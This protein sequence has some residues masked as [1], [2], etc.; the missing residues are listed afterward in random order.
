M[1]ETLDCRPPEVCVRHFRPWDIF[2]A[3]AYFLQG[4][5]ARQILV[6][7]VHGCTE[8]VANSHWLDFMNHAYQPAL[9]RAQKSASIV[10]MEILMLLGTVPRDGDALYLSSNYEVRP[11]MCAFRDFL[12][13]SIDV[14]RLLEMH[15]RRLI[16]EYSGEHG[17]LNDVMPE[18]L[19]ELTEKIGET[20]Y[21]VRSLDAIGK[22]F[23]QDHDNKWYREGVLH[24]WETEHWFQEC[25]GELSQIDQE[26]AQ[27]REEDI[28]SLIHQLRE[29][30]VESETP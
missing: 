26:Q 30:L 28:D 22:P 9:E 11:L 25:L 29:H 24:N 13:D 6:E 16:D 2:K 19:T 3:Y 27:Q 14:F 10:I 18:V 21:L 1:S 12:Q 7:S 23:P 17:S 4:L 5:D 15:S 20:D 8:A